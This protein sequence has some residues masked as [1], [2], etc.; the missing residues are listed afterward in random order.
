MLFTKYL[1]CAGQCATTHHQNLLIIMG[2]ENID[3]SPSL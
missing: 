2:G 1:L 3:E